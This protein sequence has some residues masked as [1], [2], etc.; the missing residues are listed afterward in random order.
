[1]N[2][3]TPSLRSKLRIRTTLDEQ[4]A[5]ESQEPHPT[6]SITIPPEKLEKALKYYKRYL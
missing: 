6:Y 4:F 5:P 1:M 3:E 2:I